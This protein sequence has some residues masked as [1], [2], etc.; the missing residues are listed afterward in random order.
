MAYQKT[1]DLLELAVWMQ[2]SREGVSIPEIMDRFEVSRRTAERMRDMIINHFIQA[3]EVE[4]DDS[5]KRWR[6]PQGTLK[7]L[8]Q[9]TANDLSILDLAQESL[10]KEH[11]Q[12]Q[13]DKLKTV[14]EKIKASI[15]PR[16][17]RKIEPDA[18][19]LLETQGFAHRPGPKIHI[20]PKIIETIQEA[21]LS[22][23]KLRLE[24]DMGHGK[25][26]EQTVEPYGFLYGNRHYLIAF[27]DYAKQ[28]RYYSLHRLTKVQLLDEYFVRDANFSLQDFTKDS[29]GVFKEE[30]FEVEWKFNKEVAEDAADYIFHPSQKMI[31]NPDGTL[32]VKFKAGGRLEMKW[33][34]YTWGNNVEVIK[35]KNFQ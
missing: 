1:E 24:L 23:K 19:L 6:I 5:Y 12:E 26:S 29:F 11:L 32:T 7:D 22:S 8:F 35:P 9:F 31:K 2:S 30:P 16:T 25:I 14:I 15:N 21:L 3:E 28:Y 34:L 33:H 13:A 27:S 10:K 18:E 17:Y 4:S 20:N